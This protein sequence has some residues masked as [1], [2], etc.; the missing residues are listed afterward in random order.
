VPSLIQ[1]RLARVPDPVRP[2]R[3]LAVIVTVVLAL[4]AGGCG[5]EADTQAERLAQSLQ[6]VADD[7]LTT[8]PARGILDASCEGRDAVYQCD[9]QIDSGND[10]YIEE[11]R[12]QLGDDGCWRAVSTGIGKAAGRDLEEDEHES[13][14]LS[15]CSR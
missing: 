10:V 15:G 2:R 9:L 6:E 13:R 5:E 4:A 7:E 14:V 11:F 8:G 12:V 1:G 3:A